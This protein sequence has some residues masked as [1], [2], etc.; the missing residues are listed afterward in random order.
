MAKNK[1]LSQTGKAQV[2]DKAPDA[3][4]FDML[5]CARTGEGQDVL[6]GSV[7]DKCRECGSSVWISLSGQRAMKRNKKLVVCCL[8]CAYRNHKN[9]PGLE[10][11]AAPGS[12]QEL[13]RYLDGRKK[14]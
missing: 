10:V 5:V 9:T 6:P 13:K 3:D 7:W 1:K 14:H 11:Q 8:Q 4:D 12:L 2:G